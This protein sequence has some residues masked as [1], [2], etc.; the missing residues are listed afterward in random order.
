MFKMTLSWKARALET[1][2]QQ[3]NCQEQE[4]EDDSELDDDPFADIELED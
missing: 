3:L 1:V 4:G 2:Q